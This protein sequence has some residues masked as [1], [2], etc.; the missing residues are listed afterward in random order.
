MA[1]RKAAFS[2][3]IAALAAT[4]CAAVRTADGRRLPLASNEFRA[5]VEQV[6]RRQN[7]AASELA[8][9][10]EDASDERATRLAGAEDELFDAC[11]KLNRLAT[12]RRDGRSLSIRD[13]KRAAESAPACES[14]AAAARAVLE[15][16]D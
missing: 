12:A 3:A 9:A 8:F 16:D 11:A 10:L 14:A 13:A 5:Y 6:F 15:Q 4:G 1:P 2:A 7:A